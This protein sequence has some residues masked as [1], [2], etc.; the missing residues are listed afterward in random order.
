LPRLA[1]Q[2]GRRESEAQFLGKRGLT[3]E[4][5]A[6]NLA[7]LLN[8]CI[9]FFDGGL[10]TGGGLSGRAD[11][12]LLRLDGGGKDIERGDGHGDGL[13]RKAQ[14]EREPVSN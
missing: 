10:A 7:K 1:S 12:G 13:R 4:C 2:R 6:R 5:D 14:A 8:P 3:L 9:E 11:G